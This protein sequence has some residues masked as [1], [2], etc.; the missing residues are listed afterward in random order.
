M[1]EFAGF[2]EH[3]AVLPDPRV[4]RGKKRLLMDVLFIGLAT[5]LS[6]GESFTDIVDFGEIREEW[7]SL[8]V[9]SSA[10]NRYPPSTCGGPL[11]IDLTIGACYNLPCYAVCPCDRNG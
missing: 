6:G 2:V 10:R 3:F 11:S 5:V 8:S 7:L 4:E 1:K 9:C